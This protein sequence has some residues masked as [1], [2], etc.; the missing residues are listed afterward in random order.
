MKHFIKT[1]LVTL[2]L[3]VTA[4]TGYGF[5]SE[6]AS[7]LPDPVNKHTAELENNNNKALVIEQLTLGLSEIASRFHEESVTEN[8]SLSAALNGS[9]HHA[10]E[11][12]VD[13]NYLN[14]SITICPA[15]S[16]LVL[17]FPF[18]LFP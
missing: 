9:V 8:F 15:L 13:L 7:T 17:I 5:S 14:Y 3:F 1:I 6:S 2:L 12:K 4:Q 18:H 16:R 11:Q 10:T